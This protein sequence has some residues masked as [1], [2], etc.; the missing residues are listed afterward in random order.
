MN[1]QST[2]PASE[3]AM[4]LNGDEHDIIVR[5]PSHEEKLAHIAIQRL[6]QAIPKGFDPHCMGPIRIAKRVTKEGL[7]CMATAPMRIFIHAHVLPG[8]VDL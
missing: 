8:E 1:P 5:S 6:F 4:A 3:P 2:I 7:A